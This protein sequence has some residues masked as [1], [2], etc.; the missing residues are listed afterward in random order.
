MMTVLDI[1]KVRD[2]LSHV[3]RIPMREA[4]M[5]MFAQYQNPNILYSQIT[6]PSSL[7]IPMIY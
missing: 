2:L 4:V 3:S 7:I 6:L 5:A 1:E